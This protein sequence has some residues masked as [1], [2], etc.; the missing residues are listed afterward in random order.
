[1]RKKKAERIEARARRGNSLDCPCEIPESTSWD[2]YWD[3]CRRCGGRFI[4][5]I[6]NKPRAPF[7]KITTIEGRRQRTMESRKDEEAQRK[8]LIERI[9]VAQEQKY[10]KVMCGRCAQVFWVSAEMYFL[11]KRKGKGLYCPNGHKNWWT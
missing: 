8:L 9:S 5:G 4:P 6:P 10:N 7:G 2:G 11:A 1:M 3:Q